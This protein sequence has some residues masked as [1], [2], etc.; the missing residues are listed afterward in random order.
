VFPCVGQDTILLLELK[1]C[2]IPSEE[3]NMLANNMFHY[4]MSVWVCVRVIC[5]YPNTKS[6]ANINM[7]VNLTSSL[8][9]QSMMKLH[10]EVLLL[11]VKCKQFS[12]EEHVRNIS[13]VI[14]H[15]KIGLIFSRTLSI[16]R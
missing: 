16:T 3:N 7:G 15:T 10:S 11:D 1:S 2:H 12:T 8:K 13:V 6:N 14:R 5:I 4:V 9:H